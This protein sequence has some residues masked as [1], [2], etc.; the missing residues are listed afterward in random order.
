MIESPPSL[1]LVPEI[2]S[3][4]YI[5]SR[6]KM[7]DDEIEKN[8]FSQI[9]IIIISVR[10]SKIFKINLFS[11]FIHTKEGGYHKILRNG[12]QRHNSDKCWDLLTSQP[13]LF[14]K[15]QW[16]IMT[17]GKCQEFSNCPLLT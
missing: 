12:K 7:H 16:L 1:V 5:L 15:K 13:S 3:I 11:C 10:P 9:Q 6:Q 2:V 8:E 4:N 17:A 14:L